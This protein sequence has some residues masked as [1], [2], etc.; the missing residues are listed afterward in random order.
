MRSDRYSCI[1]NKVPC[2]TS[3]FTVCL[4]RMQLRFVKRPFPA[5]SCAPQPSSFPFPLCSLQPSRGRHHSIILI[6]L[7]HPRRF[8]HIRFEFWAAHSGNACKWQENGTLHSSKAAPP[9]Y[10]CSNDSRKMFQSSSG[11]ASLGAIDS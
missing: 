7:P 1:S 2:L 5:S 11:P 4:D 6:I 9:F 8:L 10:Q 3:G